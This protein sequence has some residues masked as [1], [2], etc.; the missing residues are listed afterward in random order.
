MTRK[1]VI[2]SVIALAMC[3]SPFAAAWSGVGSYEP[4]TTRDITDGWMYP[5]ADTSACGATA[6]P[7]VKEQVYLNGYPGQCAQVCYITNPNVG[8]LHSSIYVADES[9]HAIF[10]VWKDCNADGYI[11]LGDDG[12]WDYREEVLTVPGGLGVGPGLSICPVQTEP[13]GGVPANGNWF[14]VHNDGTWIREFIPIGWSDQ[15]SVTGDHDPWNLN[16]NNARVWADYGLP[17][18]PYAPSCPLI[19]V[20]HGTFGSVGGLLH[21]YDCR[22][23]FTV[24]STFDSVADSDPTL[25]PYS[26]SDHPRDQQNSAS[27][28]NVKNPWGQA[29]DGSYAE[30]WDCSQPT[31]HVVTLGKPFQAVGNLGFY[32]VNVSQPR[33]PP[34]VTPTQAGASP[35]GT[36]NDAGSG[37]DQCH[38]PTGAD[39]QNGAAPQGIIYEGS[40]DNFHAGKSLA[41]APYL[42]EYDVASTPA[43]VTPDDWMAPSGDTYPHSPYDKAG[44]P[45]WPDPTSE[46]ATGSIGQWGGTHQW[47]NPFFLQKYQLQ[48]GGV[49]HTFYG[50]TSLAGVQTPKGAA[51]GTYGAESCGSFTTGIHNGWQCDPTKWWVN[52]QGADLKNGAR[53]AA[54]GPLNCSTGTTCGFY[55]ATVGDPYNVRDID[56]YDQS[57]GA[58]RDAGLSY[59]QLDGGVVCDMTPSS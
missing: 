10:G 48:T 58:V 50:Y 54:L 29:S 8:T 15:Q 34:S 14:P 26:F 56:C 19:P 33:V 47:T 36:V 12:L 4:D 18:E 37:F 32:Q 17:E 13:A 51:T 1:L 9:F 28:A 5:T 23:G 45:D 53:S 21:T 11:G 22:E 44:H 35:S 41:N 46:Q 2:A 38:R 55:G 16:D 39:D 30:V 59:S 3:A 52:S 25:Q 43:R 27:K 7:C 40:S 6:S 57:I 49:Y 42:I 20:E 24:T 31:T